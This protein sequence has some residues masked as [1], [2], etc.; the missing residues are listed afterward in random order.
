MRLRDLGRH[1]RLSERDLRVLR[2]LLDEAWYEGRY[3]PLRLNPLDDFCAHPL[4][5]PN[6][7][8]DPE[9]W[10]A[11]GQSKRDVV[12]FLAGLHLGVD[13]RGSA[14][15]VTI[16]GE[17]LTEGG[18][19][20]VIAH[21]DPDP[22]VL[23]PYVRALVEGVSSAGCTVVLVTS[24]GVLPIALVPLLPRVAAVLEVSNEG[25]DWHSYRS[26]L[27]YVL[28]RVEPASVVLMND[29]VFLIPA[30]FP[31]FLARA[32]ALPGE[33]VGATD[34]EQLAPH[35][36]SYFLLLRP[37]ALAGLVPEFLS[38]FRAVAEKEYVIHAYELGFSR[39]ALELGLSLSAVHS[40]RPLADAAVA[41]SASTPSVRGRIAK[42][43]P[44]NP[45][46]HLWDVL[47]EDGFPFVKRQLLRDLQPDEGRLR[48]LVPAETL[49]LADAH[50]RRVAN[51][52]EVA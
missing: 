5:R 18:R 19:V 29:S 15:R 39:R 40:F 41:R 32:D 47:L 50:L 13:D 4:R 31:R 33:I 2:A 9:T 17:R 3:G 24:S 12:P 20:A 27:A 30:A 7:W 11:S 36:Q 22:G 21:H 44:V 45:T 28:E 38:T 46:L 52:D 14:R 34:S 8:F 42:A 10:V 43:I 26:G 6:R 23:D 35:L 48:R 1:N 49:E 51:R 37:P 25:F 16:G